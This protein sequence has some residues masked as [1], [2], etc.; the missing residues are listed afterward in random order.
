MLLTRSTLGWGR[1][2]WSRFT[3]GFPSSGNFRYR[4]FIGRYHP[5]RVEIGGGGHGCSEETTAYVPPAGQQA[6]GAADQLQRRFDQ[7]GYHAGGQRAAVRSFLAEAQRD[8]ENAE[9]RQTGS[10]L[11]RRP[12]FIV[13]VA[14][15]GRTWPSGIRPCSFL[16]NSSARGRG[17][18][19]RAELLRGP[20]VRRLRSISAGRHGTVAAGRRRHS[21]RR[22]E[23]W[24]R[25]SSWTGWPSCR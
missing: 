8:A 9:F 1:D 13:G 12:A 14:R 11:L 18:T 22:S 7:T 15:R 6:A 4:L 24:D 25:I 23:L 21:D 16:R 10:A 2:C 19:S 5:L 17:R 20:A 3:W